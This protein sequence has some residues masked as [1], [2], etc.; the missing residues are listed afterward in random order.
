MFNPVLSIAERVKNTLVGSFLN[1]IGL[2]CR[3]MLTC[4]VLVLV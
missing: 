2:I 4:P 1:I 3:V